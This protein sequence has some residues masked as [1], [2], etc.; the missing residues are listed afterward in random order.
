M[1]YATI[2][3]LVM[4]F[5]AQELEQLAPGLSPGSIND[6]LVQAAIMDAC[7][8]I[9]SYIGQRY[10]LPLA[11]TPEIMVGVTCDLARFRL[12]AVNP[13]EEV[14]ERYNQRIAFLRDVSAGKAGIPVPAVQDGG[15]FIAAI[16]TPGRLFTRETLSDY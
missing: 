8:E 1:T 11:N 5:G 9:D 10:T 15:G 6:A 7:A 14:T 12:Y 2:D 13:I 16:N 3:D 4:R